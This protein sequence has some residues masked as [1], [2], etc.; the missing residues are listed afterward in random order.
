[1]RKY[2][3][4]LAFIIGMLMFALP[5]EAQ[6]LR[7]G[8]GSAVGKVESDGTVR[9]SS[10]SRIGKVE[11]DGTVRNGNGSSIGKAEGVNR[12]HA[13]ACFFFFFN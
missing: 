4:T 7:N 8:S 9:N 10:G 6:T 11:S 3:F 1:M 13:A 5:T 2:A 12:K